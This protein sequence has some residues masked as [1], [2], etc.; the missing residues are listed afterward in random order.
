MQQYVEREFGRGKISLADCRD[1]LRTAQRSAQPARNLGD[2]EE[3][4][5]D[6]A[7]LRIAKGSKQ[8]LDAL[9]K[10]RHGTWPCGC[11]KTREN[12]H[13]VA[14]IGKC[15]T[16]RRKRWNNGLRQVVNR[17]LAEAL[18]KDRREHNSAKSRQ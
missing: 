2:D 16:C 17:K 7:S 13:T 9:Q 12:I 8:L 6:H 3:S 4:P 5:F 18:I 11:L 10:A 14:G 15:R 1:I